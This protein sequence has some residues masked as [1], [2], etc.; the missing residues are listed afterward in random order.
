[1]TKA[2]FEVGKGTQEVI[3]L[4]EADVARYLEPAELVRELEASFGAL[5]RGEVQCP[6]RPEISIPHR[7]FSLT[8]SAWQPGMQICVKIVNVFDGNVACGLPNHLALIN[9]FDPESGA[10]TCVMDATYIT[11]IRTAAAAVLSHKLLS[12]P[13]SRIAT[14]V[15]AG[16]QA[17]EHLR[18]LPLVRDFDEIQICSL[19]FEHAERLASLQPKACAVRDSQAAIERSDVV[20]L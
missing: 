19:E 11:G 16:V 3:S 13:D 7:G 8:M 12:R 15:G 6:P 1:M 14:I 17:R 5:A 20:C 9:L 2:A 10:A 18:L 4:S